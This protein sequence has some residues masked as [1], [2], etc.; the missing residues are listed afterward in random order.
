MNCWIDFSALWCDWFCHLY[1]V[2]IVNLLHFFTTFWAV[3]CTPWLHRLPIDRLHFIP[4][5]VPVRWTSLVWAIS[6]AH[7]ECFRWVWPVIQI[8]PKLIIQLLWCLA[9]HQN[10]KVYRISCP[11]CPQWVYP[12]YSFF[13]ELLVIYQ[14][15]FDI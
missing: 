12:H 14:S 11:T 6:Q 4:R 5:V 9:N 1:F 15:D 13:T 2:N 3:V 7:S 10:Y 8:S